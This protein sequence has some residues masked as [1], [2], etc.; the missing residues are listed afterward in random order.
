MNGQPL[1]I[2]WSL[3]GQKIFQKAL[4]I[5]LILAY[6]KS[7]KKGETQGGTNHEGY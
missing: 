5:T 6:N 7:I 1:V 4:D 2:V 3:F